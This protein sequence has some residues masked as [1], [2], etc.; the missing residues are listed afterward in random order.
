MP[1]FP[2]ITRRIWLAYKTGRLP[3]DV[4]DELLM[5]HHFE[6]CQAC[7]KEHEAALSS[8]NY[9]ETFRRLESGAVGAAAHVAREKT[10]AEVV[11][12]ALLGLRDAGRVVPAAAEDSRFASVAVVELILERSF[13]AFP[14]NP[15]EAHYLASVAEIA[16]RRH[17]SDKRSFLVRAIAHQ[18]NA[19]RSSGRIREARLRFREARELLDDGDHPLLD[20]EVY[21][22]LDWW[23]GVLEKELRHFAEAETL[24]NRAALLYGIEREEAILDRVLLSL[25]A[26]Y[27]KMGNIEDA[28]SAVGRVLTHLKE[29][30]DPQLYWLARFNRSVYLTEAGS[31]DEAKRELDE[32]LKARPFLESTFLSRRGRWIQG[33]IAVG[34]GDYLAA[35]RHL[36]ATRDAFLAEM[37]GVNTALVSLDLALSYLENGEIG[38][39]RTIAEEMVVIFK[40]ADIHD[41]AVAALTLFQ[42]AVRRGVLT[43]REV[44]RLRR[45]LEDARHT[46]AVPFQRPS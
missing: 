15:R 29:A 19:L 6:I 9:D 3:K 24:L 12:A 23:E 10:E 16:S 17:H 40:A 4:F 38:K 18:A 28:L 36:R 8:L 42:E 7:R 21:A 35:E 39:L 34:E 22:L 25:G 31:F 11:L 46:P 45:D 41:E 37:S 43:V 14:E 32:C 26:L 27:Y 33:R 13:A 30:A 2:P 44:R 5:E 20:L 1:K